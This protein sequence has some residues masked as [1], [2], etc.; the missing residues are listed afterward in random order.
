MSIA[1]AAVSNASI[2]GDA[3]IER[4]KLAQETLK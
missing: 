2:S 1:A 3:A 4:S